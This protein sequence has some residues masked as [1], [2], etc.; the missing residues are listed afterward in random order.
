MSH[1]VNIV[2]PQVRRLRSSKEWSQNDLAIKLQILGMEHATRCKVS[3]IEARL[4]WV[5]DDDLI[6]LSR[7]LGVTTEELY[8]D[9]IRRAGRMGKGKLYEAITSS[10]A[11]RFGSLVIGGF[12]GALSGSLL[13]AGAL[14]FLSSV[15][16]V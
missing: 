6:F 1:H 13:G 4:V 5:S 7:V 11:S 9:F 2:G 12:S 16:S 3:K 10:K 15:A 8:P 14:H